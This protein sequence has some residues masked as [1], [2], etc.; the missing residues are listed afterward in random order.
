MT[1]LEL[2]A[3]I[4]QDIDNEQDSAILEKLRAYYRK[5]KKADKNI[6]CQYTLEELNSRL[7]E[8]EKEAAN[9]GGTEHDKF[10]QEVE[11]WL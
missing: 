2:K 1:T 9:G 3:Q 10:M 11:E 6:P 8:A 7:D 5:L 4:K